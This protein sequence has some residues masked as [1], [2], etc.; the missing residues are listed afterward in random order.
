MK[1]PAEIIR[2]ATLAVAA[3]LAFSLCSC[4]TY[5]KPSGMQPELT[6]SERNFEIAWRASQ[7]VLT[8]YRFELDRL[9]RREGVIVTEL[10]VGR[11]FFELWRHDCVTMRDKTE[12]SLQ[13]IYK[14]AIVTIR[15]TSPG[16]GT[17]KAVV[18]VEVSRSDKPV[19]QLTTTS[20]AYDMFVLP[21]EG[22]QRSKYLL[23]YGKDEQGDEKGGMVELEQDKDLATK[24]EADISSLVAKR[25]LR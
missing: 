5:S 2:P 24:I 3:L 16:A 21:G 1:K 10:M 17:W 7:D 22:E 8:K 14:R 4:G 12:S 19:L 13:T 18:A 23:D 6:P 20:D 25:T 9:D 15:P 11:Q